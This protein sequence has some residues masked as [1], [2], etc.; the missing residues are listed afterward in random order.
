MFHVHVHALVQISV[1]AFIMTGFSEGI[2]RG[3]VSGFFCVSTE[4]VQ[5]AD[6]TGSGS[7]CPPGINEEVPAGY[8]GG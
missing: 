3:R 4:F 7:I 6:L 8:V 2:Q 1:I 5:S